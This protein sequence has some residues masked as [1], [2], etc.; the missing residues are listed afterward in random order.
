MSCWFSRS[1][2]YNS[3]FNFSAFSF[4]K[5]EQDTCMLFVLSKSQGEYIGHF[6]SLRLFTLDFTCLLF[7]LMGFLMC[8][9]ITLVGLLRPF[10]SAWF[11]GISP[12]SYQEV[13]TFVYERETDQELQKLC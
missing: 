13:L 10:V 2:T 5:K 4:T 11:V 1:G 12:H 7:L 9:L 3:D 6:Y 8:R